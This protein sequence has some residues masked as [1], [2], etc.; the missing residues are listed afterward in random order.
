MHHHRYAPSEIALRFGKHANL[1]LNFLTEDA[2]YCGT[3]FSLKKPASVEATGR[4]RCARK[5]LGPF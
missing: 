5:R 1:K 2:D 4:L 3:I